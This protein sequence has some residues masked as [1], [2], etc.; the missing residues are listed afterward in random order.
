MSMEVIVGLVTN[1]VLL[2]S[3]SVI[4]SLFTNE[5]KLSRL[6]SKLVMGLSISIVGFIIMST[7]VEVQSGNIFDGRSILMLLSGIFFGVIPVIISGLILSLYRIVLGGAG[8]I[9]GILWILVS[10]AIGLIW[11]YFKIKKGNKD[12]TKIS[13]LEQYFALLFTQSLMVSL[14]FLFPNKVP[15]ETIRAVAIPLIVLYPLGGL[16]VSLFISTQSI[17]TGK[18]SS[19]QFFIQVIFSELKVL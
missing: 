2:M 9:P 8:I 19:T 4:Y 14:L 3:L 17:C 6:S 10:G 16:M 15:M 11:R 13:I 1:I 5:T 18:Y 12:L 7:A